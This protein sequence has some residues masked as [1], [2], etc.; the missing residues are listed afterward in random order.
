[1]GRISLA[2]LLGAAALCCF[3]PTHAAPVTVT[4]GETMIELDDFGLRVL[5]VG[6]AT[7]DELTRSATL[8]ISG[9]LVDGGESLLRHDGSGLV[10]GVDANDFVAMRALRFN[11]LD[12]TVSGRV[13]GRN[14]GAAFE[15]PDPI[16]LFTLS[17]TMT[18]TIA[19][20]GA[21]LFETVFNASGLTGRY[22]G[23]AF[24]SP[25]VAPVATPLPGSL[26]LMLAA[27]L[28]LALVVRTRPASAAAGGATA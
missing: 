17:D 15:L 10:F 27:A 8:P 9:G 16:D 1:M 18:L 24:S 3:S 5:P 4:G 23:T 28:G 19:P 26:P 25:S 12:D 6:A 13:R 7:Y 11:T 22:V 21:V 14:D 2:M 20:D